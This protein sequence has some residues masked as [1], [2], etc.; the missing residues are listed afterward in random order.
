MVASHIVHPAF[1]ACL[2]LVLTLWEAHNKTVS[3]TIWGG[4][5]IGMNTLHW[6]NYDL[7]QISSSRADQSSEKGL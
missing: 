1:Q 4:A 6:K 3:P 5:F 2:T 7:T